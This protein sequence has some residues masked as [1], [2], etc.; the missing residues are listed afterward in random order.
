[1]QLMVDN[2]MMTE[3]EYEIL[4]F[5]PNEGGWID[6]YE[7]GYDPEFDSLDDDEDEA[8]KLFD[9][10]CKKIREECYSKIK[11]V[12]NIN[13]VVHDDENC[14]E[15]IGTLS[16]EIIK[17][18]EQ[19]IICVERKCIICSARNVIHFNPN[20]RQDYEEIE[21]NEGKKYVSP[22][23]GIKNKKECICDECDFSW[24]CDDCAEENIYEFEEYYSGCDNKF[25][26]T[27]EKIKRRE[28]EKCDDNSEFEMEDC[29]NS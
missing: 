5:C 3:V 19:F 8:K 25:G 21:N 20:N 17:E 29:W 24:F 11:L 15:V 12:K 28:Q 9:K 16:T 6:Q 10:I 27:I 22:C 18:F 23:K 1:M 14:S 7:A 4:L 26:L 2:V 13:E